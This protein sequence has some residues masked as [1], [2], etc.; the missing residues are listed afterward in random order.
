MI[1][2]VVIGQ[3]LR[4][5]NIDRNPDNGSF[6]CEVDGERV[7]GSAC[8][9]ERGVLS[10]VLGTVSHRCVLDEDEEGHA[11]HVNGLRYGFRVEDPRSPKRKL[12]NAADESGPRPIKAP[13]PG[14]VVRLLV[15]QGDQ[16]EAKQGILVIEAMKM[17]NELKSTKAGRVM[18]MR[19]VPG[20]TVNAGDVL[21]IIE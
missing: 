6:V 19:A 8:W 3:R 11:V 20:A 1:L 21:A 16:V 18:E 14:R 15:E 2:H 7:E 17:Q 10:L 13:M 9:L 12:S 4:K 5:I